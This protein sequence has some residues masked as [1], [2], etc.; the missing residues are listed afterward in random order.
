MKNKDK[1]TSIIL[2]CITVLIVIFIFLTT[3]DYIK[4]DIIYLEMANIIYDFD[5]LSM[6]YIGL[7]GG[8]VIYVSMDG[9]KAFDKSGIEVWS[10]AL[11]IKDVVVSKNYPYYAISS[12]FDKK[13]Y[14]FN[15]KGKQA[16]IEMQN[17]ISYFNI[18]S[19]GMIVI[20]EEVKDGHVL[21]AYDNTG[22]FL[23]VQSGSFVKNGDYPLAA[24]ISPDNQYIIV[25]H[26]YLEGV[27]I[28]S[29]V[30]AIPIKQTGT[31]SPMLYGNREAGNL[32]YGIEFI[33]NKIWASIG[34]KYITF[35]TLD[36]EL[37]KRVD[38][39]ELLFKPMVDKM[40]TLG[41]YVPLI[42]AKNQIGAT[43]HSNDKLILLNHEKQYEVELEFDKAIQYYNATEKGVIIGDGNTYKGYNKI[44]NQY[45][46]YNAIQDI[47]QVIVNDDLMIAVTS[48]S[49]VRLVER[50]K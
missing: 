21:L 41:G 20:I 30:G 47:K 33:T 1:R 10:Q 44:G 32:V 19:N 43:I 14:I 7:N 28:E 38:V 18:N 31:T 16:E 15:E 13:V 5:P 29:I 50:G 11:T 25:S 36:G 45:L 35:Y 23:E 2:A 46:E 22:K 48:D 37:V 9:I 24:I 3:T 6:E 12:P 40:P 17:P 26:L 27:E 49:I 42:I 8:Q 34:D 39:D 4:K